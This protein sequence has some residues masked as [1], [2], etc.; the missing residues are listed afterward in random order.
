MA[1]PPDQPTVATH[2]APGSHALLVPIAAG[3]AVAIALGV[4]G[5]LHEPT[6]FAI[7]ITGFSGTQAVKAWLATGAFLLALVQLV[8]A[9][10]ME[11][12]LSGVIPPPWVRPLHRWSGRAAVLLTVPVLVHCL[13]ALG[14]QSDTPRVLI[15]SLV[16]CFFYGAFTAKMLLLT[17]RGLPGWAIPLIGGVVFATLVGLWL[18]SSLWFFTTYGVTL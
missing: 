6:A 3:A 13:Y 17:R 5:R 10:V 7:N 8:S 18:S 12:K 9:L 2:R 11:R 1:F 4:Y 14:F 15:H 16:G